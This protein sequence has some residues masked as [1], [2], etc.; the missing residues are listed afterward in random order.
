MQLNK[1]A[2][3]LCT[4]CV[5]AGGNSRV[6]LYDLN[7]KLKDVVIDNALY[8]PFYKQNIFSVSPAIAKGASVSH[9]KAGNYF[10]APHGTKFGKEQKRSL[11]CQNSIPSSKNNASSLIK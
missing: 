4:M 7:G 11:Y 9:D 6:K 2:H 3:W 10:K 5:W 8:I 1:Y